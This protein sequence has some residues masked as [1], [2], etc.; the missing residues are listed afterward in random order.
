VLP[1]DVTS[2]RTAVEEAEVLLRYSISMTDG[3]VR[4][5]T[6]RQSSGAW[7]LGVGLAALLVFGLFI[8]WGDARRTIRE[9]FRSLQFKARQRGSPGELA[10]SPALVTSLEAGTRLFSTSRCPRGHGWGSVGPSETVRLGD[11]RITVLT[12]RCTGCDAREDRYV[13]VTQPS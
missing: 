6:A 8:R 12:R 13:K 5:R 1:A 2:Y 9:R 7:I 11:Q 3:E 10:A 4:T